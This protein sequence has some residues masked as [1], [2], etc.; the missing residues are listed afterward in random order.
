MDSGGTLILS[1]G[2]LSGGSAL[3]KELKCPCLHID[4]KQTNTFQ[5]ALMVVN[6]IRDD[7]IKV[8]NVAR[9]EH[10]K[11]PRYMRTLKA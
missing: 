6:W 5:A 9:Q 7:S 1:H 10:A 11:I 3:T 4:L 8:L 2:K